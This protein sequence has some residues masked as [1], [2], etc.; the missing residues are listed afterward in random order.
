MALSPVNV[1]ISVNIVFKGWPLDSQNDKMTKKK[2]KETAS[3]QKEYEKFTVTDTILLL[4]L[5]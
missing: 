3:L 2:I 1:I 4:L 5:M